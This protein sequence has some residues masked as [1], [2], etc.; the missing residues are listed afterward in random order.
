MSA[1]N[2]LLLHQ[3][4]IVATTSGVGMSGFWTRRDAGSLY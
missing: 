2:W 1:I 4:V 3:S